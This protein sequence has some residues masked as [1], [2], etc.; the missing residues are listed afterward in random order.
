M[1]TEEKGR[2]MGDGCSEGRHTVSTD[3]LL[4]FFGTDGRVRTH[5][6]VISPHI[7]SPRGCELSAIFH[8][9]FSSPLPVVDGHANDFSRTSRSSSQERSLV[10]LLSE[11]KRSIES[12]NTR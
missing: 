1:G 4:S 12:V 3:P 5:T 9:L 6:H 8:I 7:R 11:V 2:L 10:L